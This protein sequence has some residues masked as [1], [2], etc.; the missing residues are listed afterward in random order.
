ML[1]DYVAGV[2]NLQSVTQK[3]IDEAAGSLKTYN[4]TEVMIK[5]QNQSQLLLLHSKKQSM[6]QLRPD[7][8]RPKGQAAE[9]PI[10]R[11]PFLGRMIRRRLDCEAEKT[12]V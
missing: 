4:N 8:F 10:T 12:G 7:A 2:C 9:I 5:S 6:L 11:P 1:H 3:S